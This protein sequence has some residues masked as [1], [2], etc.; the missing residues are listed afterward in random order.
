VETRGY[1]FIV[2]KVTVSVLFDGENLRDRDV[3]T[4]WW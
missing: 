2:G 4:A 3:L 1:G